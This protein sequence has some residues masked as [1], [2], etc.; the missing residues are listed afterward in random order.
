M[1]EVAQYHPHMWQTHSPAPGKPQSHQNMRNITEHLTCCPWNTQ[2]W[3]R[4]YLWQFISVKGLKLKALRKRLLS[5]F[6]EVIW[7]FKKCWTQHASQD[8]PV[9]GKSGQEEFKQGPRLNSY[10][11][12]ICK[13]ICVGNK[14][15]A[16]NM[17][18]NDIHRG[19]FST[20]SFFP[21]PTPLAGI[22]PKWVMN[23]LPLMWMVNI[24]SPAPQSL[25]VNIYR[26]WGILSY[27][28]RSIYIFPQILRRNGREEVVKVYKD[29]RLWRILWRH[30]MVEELV[31]YKRNWVVLMNTFHESLILSYVVH[32][33]FWAPEKRWFNVNLHFPCSFNILVKNISLTATWKNRELSYGHLPNF[34]FMQ[35]SWFWKILLHL[36]KCWYRASVE[37]LMDMRNHKAHQRSGISFSKKAM[38]I[39]CRQ[40]V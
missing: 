14:G 16:I 12:W 18:S 19:L 15:I 2:I 36:Q 37:V 1:Q 3:E 4:I 29:I 34:W 40:R 39:A 26:D 30:Q 31:I 10:Y 25:P 9:K 28:R 6:G 24:S 33:K 13:C 38:N 11:L 7:G 5:Y 23:W 8:P 21:S 17:C 35:A 27:L 20:S 22:Q 32:L